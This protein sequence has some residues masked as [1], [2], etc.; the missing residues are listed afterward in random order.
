MKTNYQKAE[1]NYS[2]IQIHFFDTPLLQ[3][4]DS[5]PVSHTPVN[6]QNIPLFAKQTNQLFAPCCATMEGW[7]WAGGKWVAS[8]GL[9]LFDLLSCG[10]QWQ[11]WPLF[12]SS[13]QSVESVESSIQLV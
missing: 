7:I 3:I 8:K 12:A 1:L 10:P 6:C 11:S 4:S 5:W 13:R 9:S 2:T